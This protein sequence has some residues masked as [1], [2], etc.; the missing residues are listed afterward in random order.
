M[1]IDLV[2]LR[3]KAYITFYQVLADYSAS[4]RPLTA[5]IM[6]GSD[7]YSLEEQEYFGTSEWEAHSAAPT[8]QNIDSEN[9]TT[10]RTSFDF[11]QEI[12]MP[13]LELNPGWLQQQ[14]VNAANAAGL[15]LANAFWT[16]VFGAD[17]TSHP[18]TGAAVFNSAAI[19]CVETTFTIKPPQGAAT[20]G[21]ATITQG[22]KY[23]LSFGDSSVTEMIADRAEYFDLSGNPLEANP[24]VDAVRPWMIV[25]ADNQAEAKRLARQMGPLYDG[26]GIQEGQGDTTEGVVVPFAGATTSRWALWYRRE[27]RSFVA[28]QKPVVT[29]PIAPIVWGVPRIRIEEQDKRN[30]VSLLGLGH[31]GIRYSAQIDRDL[32][33]STV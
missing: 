6:M 16:A 21:G 12:S 32:Q 5:P 8:S 20:P 10:T 30:Y 3:R 24:G 33:L 15:T 28:G 31:W 17:A 1:A 29:G 14:A 11:F 27:E 26:T 13:D 25:N 7:E 9:H 18:F 4:W 2:A 19:N 23:A 22:N